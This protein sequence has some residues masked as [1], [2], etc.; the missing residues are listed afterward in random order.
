MDALAESLG[1]TREEMDMLNQEIDENRRAQLALIDPMYGAI[2][3]QRDYREALDE[4]IRVQGDASSTSDELV[5]AVF[6]VMMAEVERQAAMDA[7]GL[8][9]EGFVGTLNRTIEAFGLEE[10]QVREL[11]SALNDYGIALETL[12]G[13]TVRTTHIHTVETVGD[14]LGFIDPRA[15]G[16]PAAPPAPTR[17]TPSPPR[18]PTAAQDA[19]RAADLLMPT[20]RAR[21]GPVM[22]GQMYVVGEEGPELFSPAVAGAIIPAGPTAQAL[23]SGGGIT[24]QSYNTY[25]SADDQALLSMLEMAQQAGRL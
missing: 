11:L 22:P 13:T 25:R 23:S 6:D 21:G 19:R 20:F 14:T 4:L 12:D 7:A 16:L 9:T 2:R 8:V 15:M 24:I 3:A 1:F 18:P 10:D 17:T 5:D